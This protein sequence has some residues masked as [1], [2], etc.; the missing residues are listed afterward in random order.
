[1][2]APRQEF[3]ALTDRELVL[4]YQGP[5]PDAYEEIFRRHN[6]RVRRVCLKMLHDPHDA[7]EAMQETFLRSYRALGRFNGRYQLG[8]WLARIATNVCL[9]EIRKNKCHVEE[10][11][12][13]EVD[14]YA[15][16]GPIPSD[17]VVEATEVH[18]SMEE[19]APLHARALVLQAVE[20]LSH[21]EMAGEL[22]MS[23]PQVKSLLHRARRSFQRAWQNASGWL[24]APL[25]GFRL[26]ASRDETRRAGDMTA[27]ATA[28]VGGAFVERLATGAVAAVIAISGLNA[29]T[30]TTPVREPEVRS[31]AESKGGGPN[32]RRARL[33]RTALLDRGGVDAAGP[34]AAGDL[35]GAALPTELT[36][37]LS[38]KSI[39]DEVKRPRDEGNNNGDDRLIEPGSTTTGHKPVDNVTRKVVDLINDTAAEG[40]GG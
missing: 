4:A 2:T 37:S 19:I 40:N 34:G 18:R 14:N 9:D 25:G 1:M 15:A 29:G 30:D 3:R 28:H 24:I 7:E 35:A 8:A 27:S 26:F 21:K 10:A 33:Q 11:P 17:V 38:L 16:T 39:S 32:V 13:E 36:N 20:G 23:T 22:D 5:H 12:V 6:E 31:Q